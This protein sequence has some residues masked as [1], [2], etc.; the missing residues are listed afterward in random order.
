[1]AA[2]GQVVFS[3]LIGQGSSMFSSD[4][5]DLDHS[6]AMPA[7]FYAIKTEWKKLSAQESINKDM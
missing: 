6:F 2:Q 7:L 4:W 3:A 5:L 1:M